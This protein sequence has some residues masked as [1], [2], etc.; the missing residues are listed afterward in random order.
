MIICEKYR[1]DAEDRNETFGFADLY[2]SDPAPQ[3]LSVRYPSS[4]VRSRRW[5][6]SGLCPWNAG[7]RIGASGRSPDRAIR[8]GNWALYLRE[9]CRTSLPG[10]LS[11]GLQT[12]IRGLSD[13][14]FRMNRVQLGIVEFR[15]LT[16]SASENQSAR[17]CFP[18]RDPNPMDRGL[19]PWRTKA[20]EHRGCEDCCFRL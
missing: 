11:A 16:S 3:W 2:D 8:F 14:T 20:G 6:H 18:A 15:P 19:R 4:G 17:D 9:R 5:R 10:R 7:S 13:R 1:Y 12:L